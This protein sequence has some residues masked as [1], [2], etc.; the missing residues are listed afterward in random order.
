MQNKSKQED[1]TGAMKSRLGSGSSVGSRDV[2][3]SRTRRLLQQHSSSAS[4]SQTRSVSSVAS[5]EMDGDKLTIVTEEIPHDSPFHDDVTTA[6]NEGGCGDRL[7][8]GVLDDNRSKIDESEIEKLKQSFELKLRSTSSSI[9]ASLDDETGVTSHETHAVANRESQHK[10]SSNPHAR[11]TSDSNAKNSSEPVV[12][13]SDVPARVALQRSV[14]VASST[15]TSGPDSTPPSPVSPPRYSQ[16]PSSDLAPPSC[17]VTPSHDHVT[18]SA[19]SPNSSLSTHASYN[20]SFPENSV[21]FNGGQQQQNGDRLSAP[22]PLKAADQVCGVFSVDI[23][24][25]SQTN[26]YSSSSNLPR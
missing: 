24:K 19:A 4:G 26:Q 2:S 10:S 21:T 20:M 25:L 23:G 16:S 7:V 3:S 5:V 8:N 15:S 9:D 14:S 17:I 1:N 13:V 18:S 11:S 22:S 12:C 6:Q